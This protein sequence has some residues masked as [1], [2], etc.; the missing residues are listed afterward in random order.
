M[1]TRRRVFFSF[2]FKRDAWRA[3]Q[4]RNSHIVKSPNDTST[5]FIDAA[6]WEKVKKNGDAAVKRWINDQLSGT[7][8]TLVLIGAKT[9]TR[10]LVLYEIGKS[11][12]KGNGLL[13]IRVHNV[14]DQNKSTDAP[15]E[16]PLPAGYYHPSQI[17]NGVYD[18]VNDDGREKI[19]EWIEQ[20]AKAA[21]R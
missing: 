19:S 9:H 3:G 2:H 6:D 12:E 20:A 8:V 21:G 10:D 17:Y 13:G 4:V 16:V 11:I 15:G 18:W 14:K 7:S 5:G 1:A